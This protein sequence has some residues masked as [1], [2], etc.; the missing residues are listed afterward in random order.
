MGP[1]HLFCHVS[2]EILLGLNSCR[3]SPSLCI[4]NWCRRVFL[5]VSG[6]VSW[7]PYFVFPSGLI[8]PSG[9]YL[10]WDWLSH[11]Q[12]FFWIIETSFQYAF[13]NYDHL[14]DKMW[15]HVLVTS[16]PCPVPLEYASLS[17][18]IWFGFE[19]FKL[20]KI[21]SWFE[22]IESYAFRT[23]FS[24]FTTQPSWPK[25]ETGKPGLMMPYQ[26]CVTVNV[27]LI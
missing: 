27:V 8:L 13:L 20:L 4:W 9:Y 23:Y 26:W 6:R 11:R 19:I 10:L 3:V 22:W 2:Q 25:T 15:L 1:N 16:L 12:C 14:V 24:S 21:I 18:F 5:A 17:H 7:C